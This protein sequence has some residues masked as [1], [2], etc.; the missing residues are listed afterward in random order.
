MRLI[1]GLIPVIV[2][3][4]I[5]FVTNVL[6][7]KMLFRPLQAKYLFKLKIPFTPGILPR[8]REKLADNIGSMVARELI[9]EEIVRERI[10]DP[11]FKLTLQNTINT[12]ASKYLD[13]PIGELR[14]PFVEASENTAI[15][16]VL[17]K[18]LYK[19]LNSDTGILILEKLIQSSLPSL[20][21][22]PISNI[23]GISGIGNLQGYIAK[24]EEKQTRV[25]DILPDNIEPVVNNA[26]LHLFPHLA[27]ALLSFLQ[28]KDTREQ[29][30]KRGRG[31]MKD[32]ILRM[33]VFQRFFISAAQYDKTLEERM[34]DIIDDLVK[35]IRRFLDEEDTPHRFS[36]TLSKKLHELLERP[37][38][39][40]LSR[41]VPEDL[42]K[43]FSGA[44]TFTISQLLDRFAISTDH[45]VQVIST[46][47]KSL[48]HSISED[49][50]RSGL[51][52]LMGNSQEKSL[53]SIF[54]VDQKK[55]NKVSGKATELLLNLVEKYLSDALKGLDIRVLVRD[56]IN[57]LEM[58]RVE[59]IVLDVL[60]NQLKWINVF[61][62]ILGA[63]I[64]LSQTILNIVSG[65]L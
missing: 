6:A 30:E 7:I 39:Y 40:M 18:L 16:T 52:S 10:R 26:L 20:L 11:A 32:A 29:L 5:G 24:L 44:K 13:M 63:L 21:N 31:F 2:G 61:G 58:I 25:Q 47:A 43:L 3:A 46:S 9:T 12:L 17:A 34:P 14:L 64:G 59:R 41:I 22:M 42:E 1:L 48:L 35:H 36:S 51:Q 56:R 65:M 23:I 62:A 8:Q 37:L 50:I 4:I 55:Q 15:D 53:R 27:N 57:S 33:N 54:S 60:A 38:S 45:A 49:S 28:E 19:I